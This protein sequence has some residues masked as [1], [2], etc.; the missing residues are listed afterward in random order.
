M[1]TQDERRRDR[2]EDRADDD[3]MTGRQAD[4]RNQGEAGNRDMGNRDKSSSSS[5]KPAGKKK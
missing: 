2:D 5:G 4:S 1:S 3:G